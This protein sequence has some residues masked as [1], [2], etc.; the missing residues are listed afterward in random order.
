M[1][2]YHTSINPWNALKK[3]RQS[4]TLKKRSEYLRG[5]FSAIKKPTFAGEIGK[6]LSSPTPQTYRAAKGGLWYAL[7]FC[8]VVFFAIYFVFW[9]A[10]LGHLS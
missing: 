1:I 4:E 10:K 3:H 5:K 7:I 6:V 8:T 9:L 2:K